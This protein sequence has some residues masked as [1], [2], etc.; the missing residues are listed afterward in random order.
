VG[1]L[2]LVLLSLFFKISAIWD[3]LKDY[4][5][6]FR[7]LI[8]VPILL[9]GQPLMDTVFRMIIGHLREA[10]LLPS[11]EQ[12]KMDRTIG[13]L[14]RLRDSFVAEAIIVIIAYGN[15]A[16]LI[17]TRMPAVHDWALGISVGF[18]CR[19]PDGITRW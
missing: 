10:E 18:I 2:P 5:V 19:P 17:R 16:A 3:L 14:I 4:T 9:L 12:A 13:S 8:A 11:P 7:M 1:W 6:N 15:V